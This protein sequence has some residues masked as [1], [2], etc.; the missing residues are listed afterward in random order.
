MTFACGK[1]LVFAESRL[2]HFI[3]QPAF[4]SGITFACGKD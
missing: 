4:S 1:D 2:P 3:W